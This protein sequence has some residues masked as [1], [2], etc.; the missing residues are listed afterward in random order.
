MGRKVNQD[1]KIRSLVLNRVV[2][3]MFFLLNKVRVWRPRGT[4][5]YPNFPLV[6]LVH[7]SLYMYLRGFSIRAGGRRFT[8]TRRL[9][10]FGN[11]PSL[12]R[13]LVCCHWI[14]KPKFND[15]CVLFKHSNFCS[16]MLEMHS[17]CIQIFPGTRA[18]KSRLCREFVS[19]FTYSKAFAI[20]LKSY[21][22]PWSYQTFFI[23]L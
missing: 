20:Y 3:W 9:L 21:Q 2:K 16:R 13:V 6:P 4:H 12:N 7:A 8:W 14:I 23:F 17:R 15:V 5:L 1:H 19:F 22:K 10:F 11:Y 18:H